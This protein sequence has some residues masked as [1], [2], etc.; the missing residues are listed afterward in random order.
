[1]KLKFKY[2]FFKIASNIV[3]RSLTSGI[4]ANLFDELISALKIKD[5]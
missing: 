5:F 2:E 3:F 1:M 4:T